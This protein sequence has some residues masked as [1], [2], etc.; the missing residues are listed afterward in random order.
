MARSQ[1]PHSR[2]SVV[3]GS[4]FFIL[5]CLNSSCSS[6]CKNS[7]IHHSICLSIIPIIHISIYVSMYLSIHVSIYPCIYLYMYLS[8]HASM[9]VPIYT[10]IYL[11]MY[12]SIHVSIYISIHLKCSHKTIS[13][14][15]ISS[16]NKR[17]N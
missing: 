12:L 4:G 1:Q 16:P 5:F 13:Q 8:I 15:L 2:V 6:V 10:C 3:N 11:Y 14:V 9:Y 17:V 7:S